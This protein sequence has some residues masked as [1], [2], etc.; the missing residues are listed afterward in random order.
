MSKQIFLYRNFKAPKKKIQPKCLIF[1]HHPI[2]TVYLTTITLSSCKIEK[3]FWLSISVFNYL[4]RSYSVW[5]TITSQ[6]Q[7]SQ[8]Y[9]NS[10][11]ATPHGEL[12]SSSSTHNELDKQNSAKQRTHR[13]NLQWATERTTE[14]TYL[15][16]LLILELSNLDH[17]SKS[18]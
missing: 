8:N 9:I 13:K 7:L 5:V 6:Q 15:R 2:L 17:R 11:L 4:L 16:C 1:S 12:H 10:P 3:N 18:Q 14:R